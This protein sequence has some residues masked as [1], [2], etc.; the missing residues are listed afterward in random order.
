MVFQ[1]VSVL[2]PLLLFFI[3]PLLVERVGGKPKQH[4]RW[5]A[6]ACLVFFVS[7]YLP[8]PFLIDGQDTSF[9]THFVGGGL[10]SGLFWYYLKRSF[11]W[12]AYWLVEAASLFVLVSVLGVMN[13]LFEI[14]LYWCGGMSAGI[15]DTSWDLL[16]NTLGAFSFWLVYIAFNAQRST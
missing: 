11:R 4:R 13:E 16:A 1:I 12:Q 3:V 7:W 15:A 9:V 8:T 6:V 2:V 14:V 10:F 5:L